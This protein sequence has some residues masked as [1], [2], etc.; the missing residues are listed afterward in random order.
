M[1]ERLLFIEQELSELKS[2]YALLNDKLQKQE[3]VKKECVDNLLKTKISAL[4]RYFHNRFALSMICMPIL[5]IVFISQNF[6]PGFI[7]L[8]IFTG[9]LQ[10]LLDYRSYKLLDP[11]NLPGLSMVDASEKI[12]EYKKNNIRNYKI[13]A[14]PLLL[15]I[16]WTVLVASNYGVNLPLLVLSAFCMLLGLLIGVRRE[17]QHRKNLE[18]ALNKIEQLQNC[19]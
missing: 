19:H 8:I 15:L 11:E 2:N 5:A 17:K 12:I 6:H 3:I 7:A 1:T 13:I 9:L 14:L 18:D 4:G 10:L 16:V